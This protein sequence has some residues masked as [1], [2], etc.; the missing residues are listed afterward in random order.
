MTLSDT[1]IILATALSPLIAVQVTQF[2]A[3]KREIRDRKLWIFK[4]LMATRAQSLSSLHVEALNR[5]DL[6]FSPKIKKE[7]AVLDVWSYYLDHMSS[8]MVS[9]EAWENRRVDL[10]ID[11]LYAMGIAVGYNFNKT[12]IKN[13][14]YN[15]VAHE[16]MDR[17]NEQIRQRL[18][19]VLG[20]DRSL[21]MH[22][23]SFSPPQKNDNSSS[24]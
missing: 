13:A 9:L 2:L 15:P 21:P 24:T 10:L 3:T 8:S 17:E 20:G 23:T 19:E 5:I 12:Q 11:L 6:E 1:L 7:K 22:I 4:T 16:R 18:L 14:I